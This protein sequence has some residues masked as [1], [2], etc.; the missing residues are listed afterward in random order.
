MDGCAEE[1]ETMQKWICVICGY[2]YDEAVGIPG[3]GIAA[4][5]A[6]ADLPEEWTCPE[7]GSPKESFEVYT[8]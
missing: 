4:G 8:D 6:F 7:C 1:R 2:V 5:T 3:A